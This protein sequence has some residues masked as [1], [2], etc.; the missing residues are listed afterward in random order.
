MG[1]DCIIPEYN[2][3][4]E[5]KGK[6]EV[7][8]IR[9]SPRNLRLKAAESGTHSEMLEELN[10]VK[11]MF[12]HILGQVEGHISSDSVSLKLYTYKEYTA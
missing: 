3:V 10:E 2:Q 4:Y 8:C 9:T 1:I 11:E 12:Q 7:E 5:I 6:G